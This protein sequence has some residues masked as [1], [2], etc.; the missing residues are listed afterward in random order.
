MKIPN[1]VINF[2][3]G[4]TKLDIYKQFIDYYNHYRFINDNSKTHLEFEKTKPDGS[5]F[6]F[7]EK[8]ELVNKN[9]LSEII[10]HAGINISEF[11]IETFATN[12]NFIWATFAVIDSLIDVVLPTSIIET[13]GIYADVRNGGFGD[14]FKFEIEPRDLFVVSKSG[15][16]QRSTEMRKYF[17]GAVTITPEAHEIT[18]GVSLYKVLAGKEN[19]ANFVTRAVRSMETQM[20][21]DVYNAFATAMANLSST[22]TTGLLISG[23][24]QANLLRLCQQVTAW[25][26]GA[27]AVVMG[28]PSALLNV[29]PDDA[30]YRYDFDSPYVKVGHLPFISGYDIMPIPQV[31]DIATPF[32]L[33]IS[34]SYLWIVS[35]S[36]QKIIKL[37]IEG[38]TLANTGGAYSNAN[39]V[40]ETVL[41]KMWGVGVATNAVA[42]TIT[43]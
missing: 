35:P 24:S 14:N 10:R 31:V 12:P 26:G 29:L 1:H 32:G 15:H 27:K 5:T 23:Y 40:Q 6:T 16:A 43:L 17:R 37:C 20:M 8:E 38:S 25:N 13:T 9:L 7:A 42:G 34:N 4:E 36:A 22:T 28:T 3:G 39:L 33:A 11:S 30:N 41:T 21:L 2:A 19:L 18:V